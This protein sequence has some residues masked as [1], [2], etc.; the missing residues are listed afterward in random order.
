MTNVYKFTILCEAPSKKNDFL[1]Y[2]ESTV[3]L[4]PA[5]ACVVV[6]AYVFCLFV[7][8]FFFFL[9]SYYCPEVSYQ[10]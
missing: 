10:V 2:V 1:K 5:A 7:V 8:V 6:Q 4:H 3:I 9:F